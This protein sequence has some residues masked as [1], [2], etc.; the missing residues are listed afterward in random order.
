[1]IDPDKRGY[2]KRIYNVWR[3]ERPLEATEQRIVVQLKNI[4]GKGWLSEVQI[5][6]IKIDLTNLNVNRNSNSARG[7]TNESILEESRK[8]DVL[9]AQR[10]V[11]QETERSNNIS[12]S[13]DVG[14]DRR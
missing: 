2:R 12:Y 5:E 10:D 6:A 8:E 14:E 13:Y 3:T 9:R 1:M 7:V 4:Q 11:N